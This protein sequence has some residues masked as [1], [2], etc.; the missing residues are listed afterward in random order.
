MI[1]TGR[2]TVLLI[3]DKRQSSNSVQSD[4]IPALN[5][6]AQQTH[7]F[8][9][10]LSLRKVCVGCFLLLSR[11]RHHSRLL[12]IYCNDAVLSNFKELELIN[13]RYPSQSET[14][15]VCH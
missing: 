2:T 3:Y 15:G 5:M 12:T 11:I 7:E 13:Y 14:K 8:P 9:R 6:A 1:F 4:C 10:Q